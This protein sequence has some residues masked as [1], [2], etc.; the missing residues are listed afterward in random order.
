MFPTGI[1]EYQSLDRLL[2]RSILLSLLNVCYTA[3]NCPAVSGL[4]IRY[5]A[6]RPP[7]EQRMVVLEHSSSGPLYLAM[8]NDAL[9]VKQTHVPCHVRIVCATS[10]LISWAMMALSSLINTD[11]GCLVLCLQHLQFHAWKMTLAAD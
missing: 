7:Q 1:R 3:S 6:S 4:R 8:T 11:F 9:N 5:S 2:E 10:A